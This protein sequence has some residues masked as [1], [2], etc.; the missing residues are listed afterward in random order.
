MC[1]KRVLINIPSSIF[2]I[3]MDI[4]SYLGYN[5]EDLS[6]EKQGF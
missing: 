1:F 5:I 4:N 6:I 2:A 3:S